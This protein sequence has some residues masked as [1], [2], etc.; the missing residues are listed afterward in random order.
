MMGMLVFSMCNLAISLIIAI[1]SHLL[2]VD[3]VSFLFRWLCIFVFCQ[4]MDLLIYL[5]IAL[6]NF[7][8]YWYNFN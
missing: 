4:I 5:T 7:A 2:E 6:F 8:T 3:S 1:A